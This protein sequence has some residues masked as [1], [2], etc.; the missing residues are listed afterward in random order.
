MVA[1]VAGP[2]RADQ[3]KASRALEPAGTAVAAVPGQPRRAPA[4]PAWS[5]AGSQM[6]GGVVNLIWLVILVLMVWGS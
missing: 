5:A 6:M 2:D 4:R 1:R 3:R